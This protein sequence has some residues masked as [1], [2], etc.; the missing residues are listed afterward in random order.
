MALPALGAEL[1]ENAQPIQAGQHQIENNH[2]V[3]VAQG[4]PKTLFP[5]ARGI[6]REPCLAQALGQRLAQRFVILYEQ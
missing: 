4:I 6:D 3:V 2:V 1:F 5:V